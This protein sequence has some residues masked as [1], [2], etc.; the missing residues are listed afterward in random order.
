[1]SE[2]HV[3]LVSRETVPVEHPDTDPIK[4][5]VG[6]ALG[7]DPALDT[8]WDIIDQYHGEDPDSPQLVLAH[9]NDKFDPLNRFHAPLR[10]IRGEIV[11]LDTGAIVASSYGYTETLPC[12]EPLIFERGSDNPGGVVSMVT[13]TVKYTNSYELAPEEPAKLGIG[14]RKFQ[15]ENIVFAIGYEGTMIRIF[16]WHDKVFFSTHKRIDASRSQWGDRTTFAELWMK[17][18]GP[19]LE[20][21]FGQEMYSPYCYIFL[22]V[23]NEV[24]LAS[25]TRDNRIVFVGV[26]K[27]WT[28]ESY[29]YKNGPYHWPGYLELE[30]PEPEKDTSP[31]SANPNHALVFQPRIDVEMAN[32]FLFP[33]KYAPDFPD[34]PEAAAF[35]VKN[36]ELLIQYNQNGKSIDEIYFKRT[37]PK[38]AVIDDRLAGGDFIIAQVRDANGETTVYRIQSPAFNYRVKITDDDPVLY[39]RFVTKMVDFTK[40]EPKEI[41]DEYPKYTDNQGKPPNLGEPEERMTYWYSLFYDAVAPA[42]KDKV[43]GFYDQYEADNKKVAKFILN[44][45][46]SL[47]DAEELKRVGERTHARMNDLYNRAAGARGD[48][49]FIVLRN[50]LYNETGPSYYRMIRTVRDI[51]KY[52]N[53]KQVVA[54][55]AAQVLSE[56][57]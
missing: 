15:S 51:E 26:K 4:A 47:K 5:F 48:R 30:L 6:A 21:F 20:S 33:H 38:G 24:R 9:Y 41:L 23:D 27:V 49:Q 45:F 40:A 32:K 14:T 17:L 52:R 31:F 12:Y 16:K 18:Q 37:Y 43:D 1:M 8:F 57:Q 46:R 3:T 39:H 10:K 2:S 22:L 13:E 44:E 55:V 7:L 11:D 19:D 50:L 28:E 54:K 42:F 34:T 35:D 56:S 36:N 25:S 53:Q 29:S